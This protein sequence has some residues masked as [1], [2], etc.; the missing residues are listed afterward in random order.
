MDDGWCDFQNNRGYC[1]WDGGDCCASTVRGGLVRL[2][3]P[4][5]CTSI[6]CQCIDP[7]AAENMASSSDTGSSN[8]ALRERKS[9]IKRTIRYGRH[10]SI[11][12]P[13]PYPVVDAS[14]DTFTI[15]LA[16]AAFLLR[17]NIHLDRIR[18]S[19][20]HQ[21]RDNKT[22]SMSSKS[23]KDWEAIKRSVENALTV[24]QQQF[25]NKV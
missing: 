7:F 17:N 11:T 4:S 6:L 24:Y 20:Q 19:N 25:N 5:L 12:E 23:T 13:M 9:T 8:N 15:S 3:F 22:K 18:N 1:D 14:P 2:M 21:Q 10:H 16:D